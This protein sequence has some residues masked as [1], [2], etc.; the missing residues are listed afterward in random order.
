M[1]ICIDSSLVLKL[2]L[3][4]EDSD[5][6]QD[7]WE[8]WDRRDTEI[9]AP[10]LLWHEVTSVLRNHVHRGRLTTEEGREALDSI[11]ALS[12]LPEAPPGL[13]VRAW[14]LVN[15]LGL[16]NAYDAYYLALAQILGC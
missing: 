12:I 3:W 7:L 8:G 9:I 10:P 11:L 13:H 1:P 15:R 16:P 2:V 6:V 4:E 5:Q 14:E